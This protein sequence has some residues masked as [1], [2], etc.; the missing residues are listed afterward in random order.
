MQAGSKNIKT[1]F[2]LWEMFKIIEITRDINM[3][4]ISKYYLNTNAETN[5]GLL[6]ES[7]LNSGL[8]YIPRAGKDN[9]SEIKNWAKKIVNN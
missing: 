3:N 4:N 9:F 5:G 8:I 1:D 2:N 6:S 7:K